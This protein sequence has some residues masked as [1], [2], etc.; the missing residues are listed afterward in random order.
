[1]REL[2]GDE[3]KEEFEEPREDED[4]EEDDPH[5]PPPK[6]GHQATPPG[7]GVAEHVLQDVDAE[8]RE[9]KGRSLSGGRLLLLLLVLLLAL[10]RILDF[11]L[12]FLSSRR[13][14]VAVAVATG[15]NCLR[16]LLCV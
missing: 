8:G 11:L 10:L 14:A 16:L 1:V 9:V 6:E 5:L 4:R 3:T 2:A 7:P 13:L 15:H 12:F